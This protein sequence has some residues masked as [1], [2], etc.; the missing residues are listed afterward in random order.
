MPL[1][2]WNRP[3]AKRQDKSASVPLTTDQLSARKEYADTLVSHLS[4]PGVLESLGAFITPGNDE[5]KGTIMVAL[6]LPCAGLTF[7]NPDGKQETTRAFTLNINAT[8]PAPTAA[9]KENKPAVEVTALTY[10][11]LRAKQT[12]ARAARQATK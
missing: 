11:E 4:K 10:S 9:K 1:S 8:I 5:E 12:A 6:T 7:T 3:E 2:I